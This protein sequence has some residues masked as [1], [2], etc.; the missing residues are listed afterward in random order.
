MGLLGGNNKKAGKTP[1]PGARRKSAPSGAAVA[2]S[3]GKPGRNAPP[4]PPGKKSG[5]FKKGEVARTTKPKDKVSGAAAPLHDRRRRLVSAREATLRD[6]GGLMLEMYKRNRFREELLLDKCEEVLAIEVEIAHIDQR[7]FQLA[8]PNAAGMRPIGRCECGAPIHPG[9]NF[10][11][12]CGRS[13]ATLTQSR[14][15]DRCGSGLR[16]GDAFCSTCGNQ[17]PDVL[18]AI[19]APV[20]ARQSTST[21]PSFDAL[22][23]DAASS[24]DTVVVPPPPITDIGPD[25]SATSPP[26]PTVDTP[27]VLEVVPAEPILDLNDTPAPEA[28]PTTQA[29]SDAPVAVEPTPL[30]AVSPEPATHADDTSPHQQDVIDALP[31]ELQFPSDAAPELTPI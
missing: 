18:E 13:F 27:P 14:N 15:C 30:H 17:A 16:P 10:C 1:P 2:K 19:E 5:R 6:L 25:S 3:G 21:T 4:G 7:L 8:P 20:G 24:A 31:G 26:L 29:A 9:Q 22:P 28:T 23:A 11:G 12:V